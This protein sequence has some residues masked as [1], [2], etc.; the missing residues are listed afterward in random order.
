MTAFLAIVR[1]TCRSAFRSNF[2]RGTILF[3][4]GVTLLMPLIVK[5]DGTAVSMIKITLEYSLTLAAAL[6][7]ISAVWLG[8]S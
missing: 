1:L 7:S 3:F 6:L 8:A 2:F 5:S 4:I